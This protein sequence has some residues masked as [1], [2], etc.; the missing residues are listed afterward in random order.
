MALKDQIASNKIFYQKTTYTIFM[1]LA[2]TIAPFTAQSL[3]RIL[4]ADPELWECTIAHLP[5]E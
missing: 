5:P 1:Y 3:K 4:R 2:P